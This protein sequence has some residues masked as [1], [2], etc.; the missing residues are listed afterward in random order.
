[1]LGL[2]VEEISY[3]LRYSCFMGESE[4]YSMVYWKLPE[5]SI[6]YDFLECSVNTGISLWDETL[7]R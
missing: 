5:E 3:N 2:E 6:L 7:L 4:F 1:M